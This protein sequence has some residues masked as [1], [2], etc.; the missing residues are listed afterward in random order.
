MQSHS[1]APSP[2]RS[3][4]KSR[5]QPCGS[6]KATELWR[7]CTAGY[8]PLAPADSPALS[9]KVRLLDI[10]MGLTFRWFKHA[11]I[12][13]KMWST[14]THTKPEKQCKLIGLDKHFGGCRLGEKALSV[15]DSHSQSISLKPAAYIKIFQSPVSGMISE[16][17]ASCGNQRLI[18]LC[19]W[20]SFQCDNIFKS[21]NGLKIH[22]GKLHS[23]VW[24]QLS[25]RDCFQ[26]LRTSDKG[27]LR[28]C[29]P[30]IDGATP[31]NCISWGK[32]T[33]L[34]KAFDKPS[35]LAAENMSVM[36]MQIWLL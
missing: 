34:T 30:V 10:E 24:S 22:V 9:Y 1:G 17:T 33:D 26:L 21:E 31:I 12:S 3:I 4:C 5:C 35:L 19:W 13:G 25:E 2:P 6:Q 20:E 16:N 27:W 36:T 23:P 28:L 32:E 11:R 7:P 14:Y 29:K 18:E 8:T 15:G